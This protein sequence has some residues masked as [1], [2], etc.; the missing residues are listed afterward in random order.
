[1]W[2]QM[3]KDTSSRSVSS[4]VDAKFGSFLGSV[5]RVMAACIKVTMIRQLGPR[6]SFCC[7][8]LDAAVANDCFPHSLGIVGF[9]VIRH[10]QVQAQI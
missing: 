9:L 4:F 1:M 2:F 7:S 8:F 10:G 6:M 3:M 5:S